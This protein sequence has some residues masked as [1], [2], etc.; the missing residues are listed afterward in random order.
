M[1]LVYDT[2][3][4]KNENIRLIKMT[5]NNLINYTYNW[6]YNRSIS[7]EKV[8][9]FF[10]ELKIK[11]INIGWTLHAF[12]CKI[13]G[14][15]KLLDGQHRREAIKLY[16]EN[17]DIDMINNEEITLW[18]Y[19]IEDEDNNEDQILEMFEK[20]NNNEPIDKSQLPSK[21]KIQL[22]K[23]I[24]KEECFK[25][26]IR[27][28]INTIQSKSPYISLKQVN[29]IV[30]D[31]IK[32]YPELSNEEIIKKMKEMNRK[33]SIMATNE[34]IEE[35]LFNRKLNKKEKEIIEESRNIK[36]YLN[37]KNSKYDNFK[38]IDEL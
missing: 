33:I 7:Q 34:N 27:M 35:Q 11:S 2:I 15:I 14:D 6:I 23:M 18:I 26:G 4:K 8:N 31:I 32:K 19:E 25:S 24:K 12:M 38:W 36:F 17:T 21:R 28:N 29:K 1:P 3:Y 20:L 10:N 16:L 30:D 37:L 13:T 5:Y 22:S 9:Y